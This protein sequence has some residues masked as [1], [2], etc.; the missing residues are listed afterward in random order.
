MSVRFGDDGELIE[1]RDLRESGSSTVLT[2]PPAMLEAAGM[3][4]GDAVTITI[5]PDSD[6]IE[7]R[8]SEE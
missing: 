4:E 7:L 8:G 2:L 1:D 6:T 3:S 5:Q